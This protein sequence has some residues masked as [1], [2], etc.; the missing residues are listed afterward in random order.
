MSTGRGKSGS[1]EYVWIILRQ[2]IVVRL[3]FSQENVV[4][5]GKFK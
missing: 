3:D 1:V 5:I 2:E 4:I